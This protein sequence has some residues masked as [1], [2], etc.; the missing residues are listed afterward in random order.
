MPTREIPCAASALTAVLVDSAPFLLTEVAR[1]RLSVHYDTG[2]RR[3]PVLCVCTPE[4]IRLPNAVVSEELPPARLVAGDGGFRA[5]QARWRVLR[6][7]RPPA[8]RWLPVPDTL[9]EGAAE[10]TDDVLPGARR[11][12][13][14]YDGLDPL[15]L[16]GAGAGLTPAGDDVLAGALVAAHATAD[17]RLA[18]WQHR[19]RVALTRRAT[20]A[21][22]RGLLHAA[23]DGY[24]TPQ[25]AR[26]LE[27]VCRG[28]DT[29][30]A[31]AALLAVGHSSGAALW[32][33][34]THTLQT[35]SS[36]RAA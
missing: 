30:A 21:V 22:S 14:T 18:H 35:R 23:L 5:G 1:T 11:P 16:V 20:T 12:G 19:T 31:I 36:R 28:G 34:A 9:P 32:H 7:W 25:L 4:A 27:A 24:A 8:P 26:A 3:L 33:G 13:P 15:R 17:P 6:W 2:R 10:L 29:G